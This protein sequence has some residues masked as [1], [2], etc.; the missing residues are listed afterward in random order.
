[1]ASKV[2]YQG[3]LSTSLNSQLPVA[4]QMLPIPKLN[5]TIPLGPGGSTLRQEQLQFRQQGNGSQSQISGSQS[6]T[7]GLFNA[8]L[9]NTFNEALNN[10]LN[11][12]GMFSGQFGN[13]FSSGLSTAGNTIFNNVIKGSNLTEGLAKDV[14]NSVLGTA[15][16][17]TANL[18]GQGINKLG[19]DSMLSRGIGQGVATGLG[20]VGGAALSNILQGNRAFKG[21]TAAKDAA[22]AYKAAIDAGKTVKEAQEIS[23]ATSLASKSNLIGA[24]MSIAGSALGA[25]FGPSKEYN[26]RYGN[27]TKTMDSAYDAVQGAVGFIPGYGQVISGAMALNKGLSNVFGSTDG[28]CVCAGTKVYTASG[29]IVNIEDLVQSQGIIGWNENTCEIRPNTIKGII[30]PKQ[31]ECLEIELKNGTI[32]R[33]SI[34]HPILSN[35]K[36]KAETHRIGGKRIAYRDWEFRRADELK[37]G[38]FVGLANNI[39][40][41]GTEEMPNAYLVGMLI[42]DGTYTYE[43]SCRLCSVDPS[44][45]KYIEENNL[46]VINNCS[47]TDHNKYSTEYRTYRIINGMQLMKDL[48][49]AYQ[50]GINK[51]FPKNLGKYNKDSICKMIA[52]LY[53]TDGSISINEEKGTYKI[54][55]Y[56]SNLNLLHE[57]RDQLHKL[58][59]FSTIYTRKASVNKLANGKIINSSQSYRLEITDMYSA[60]N[61]YKNIPLNIDY[62]KEHLERIH[63]ML[64]SKKPQEHNELSGAKQYKIVSIK[65]IGIQTVYNLEAAE[66]HTYIANGIITHNTKTDAILGSAFMPAP[67]KWVNM[68]GSSKTGNFDNQS[69]QNV[70]KANSFMGNAFGDLNDKFELAREEANK[71]YGTFSQG[72][73]RRAQRNIYFANSVWGD[74]LAMADQNELQNIRSQYMSANNNQRYAQMIQGGYNP[75]AIGRQGMKILNNETNH[76][77]GQ[78]LLSA[79]ALIDNKAMIL[80]A[81]GDTKITRQ[82]I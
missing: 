82:K 77:M 33:C 52:G 56:Q 36:P 46:G 67:V 24:G 42:G 31:K 3:L 14:G 81:Q 29:E 79:A 70:E 12:T 35:N 30:E 25:A 62:K 54:T 7:N 21:F 38:D 61:F 23:K 32:L 28:M 8:A 75:L 41:W 11:N 71:R 15:S 78:R 20:S 80:S 34:D 37:V 9:S 6:K 39:D 63:Q 55:F 74:L 72:A 73:K 66:D 53:D 68:W 5:I 16:G 27:I 69:W 58:G 22:E 10:T 60:N 43:S 19:G 13:I 4:Q 50:S 18:I 40:Y 76:N 1:M 17:L 57:L 26:G 64:L 48:G 44:T 59:I 65:S 2:N 45:W 47:G 51:T 49:I